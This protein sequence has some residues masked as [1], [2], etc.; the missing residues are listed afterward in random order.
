MTPD[1]KS[2]RTRRTAAPKR[3]SKVHAR[4]ATKALEDGLGYTFADSALL[5]TARRGAGRSELW[6]RMG[7]SGD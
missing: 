2:P 1:A 3:A 5:A 4:G 6:P 7:R